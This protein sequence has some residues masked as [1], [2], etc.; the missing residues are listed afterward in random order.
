M[1]V[2]PLHFQQVLVCTREEVLCVHNWPALWRPSGQ[3][4]SVPHQCW[5]STRLV[6]RV[7]CIDYLINFSQ[8][9]TLL[10]FKFINFET[11]NIWKWNPPPLFYA[12]FQRD[13]V[14]CPC[15][16]Y[17][18]CKSDRMQL[19]AYPELQFLAELKRAMYNIQCNAMWA[20]NNMQ[21][22]WARGKSSWLCKLSKN[23]AMGTSLIYKII[24][25]QIQI[26][27]IR[28]MCTNLIICKLKMCPS[29]PSNECTAHRVCP[30]EPRLAINNAYMSCPGQ[31]RLVTQRGKLFGLD[32][33][34]ALCQLCL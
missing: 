6:L 34:C 15:K 10:D 11:L 8:K 33:L 25:K 7:E 27:R 16:Y 31:Y 13:A 14:I 24:C 17:Q 30:K 23:C 18:L 26:K 29:S 1:V 3:K 5:Q 32:A 21:C 4:S 2:S 22:A 9:N 12:F 19:V 28:A 20:E